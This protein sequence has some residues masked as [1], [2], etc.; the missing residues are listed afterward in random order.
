MPGEGSPLI[1]VS[2]RIGAGAFFPTAKGT[3]L[4]KAGFVE[5]IQLPLSQVSVAID[6]YLGWHSFKIGAAMA[7]A[8]V[9]D[10]GLAPLSCSAL[11]HHISLWPSHVMSMLLIIVYRSLRGV[12]GWHSME[13]CHNLGRGRAYINDSTFMTYPLPADPGSFGQHLNGPC[14]SCL[15]CGCGEWRGLGIRPFGQMRPPR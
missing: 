14:C 5:S 1:H 15:G 9:G 2:A 7:V 11:G 13:S 12:S 4:T 8:Q 6:G 3:P 10:D